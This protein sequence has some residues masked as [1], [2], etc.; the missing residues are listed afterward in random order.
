[1]MIKFTKRGAA[2]LLAASLAACATQP[3][4]TDNPTTAD[5]IFRYDDLNAYLDQ[6]RAYLQSLEARLSEID[7]NLIFYL[8]E[9]NAAKNALSAT[10]ANV[11]ASDNQRAQEL[12][13]V[14]RLQNEAENKLDEVERAKARKREL[15]A[16]APTG[17]S[18]TSADQE[19]LEALKARISKLESEIGG[20]DR[21]IQ[22]TLD[23]RQ[24]QIL[25][26]E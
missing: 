2:I 25:R 12:A 22:R 26:S 7:T 24:K 9:L 5:L 17:Q 18:Q 14:A 23:T 6:R 1:M 21:A 11:A 10:E 13:E 15:E 19:E 3:V 16:S 8:G 4:N 20:L